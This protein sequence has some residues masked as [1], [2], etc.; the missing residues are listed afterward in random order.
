MDQAGTTTNSRRAWAQLTALAALPVLAL[1]LAITLGSRH[2]QGEQSKD[3]VLRAGEAAQLE[4][5]Q[6]SAMLNYRLNEVREE[7]LHLYGEQTNLARALT[8]SERERLIFFRRDY[9]AAFSVLVPGQGEGAAIK[10]WDVQKYFLRDPQRQNIPQ[11][12]ALFKEA[13]SEIRPPGFIVK[14]VDPRTFGATWPSNEGYLVGFISNDESGHPFALVGVFRSNNLLSFCKFFGESLGAMPTNSFVLNEQGLV[15]CHSSARFEGASFKDFSFY[16]Q[17]RAGS[18]LSDILHYTS[19]ANI[20]VSAVT[21]NVE[22]TPFVLVS[23]AGEVRVVGDQRLPR[24]IFAAFFATILVGLASAFGIIRICQR[25][26][27]AAPAPVERIPS[28]SETSAS[29]TTQNITKNVHDNI[30]GD[31]PTGPEILPGEAEAL[32]KELKELSSELL[33]IQASQAFIANFQKQVADLPPRENLG[34]FSVHSMAPWQVPMVWF[35]KFDE[36]PKVLK[37]ASAH[38]PDEITDFGMEIELPQAHPADIA[39]DLGLKQRLAE[40]LKWDVNPEEVRIQPVY[41]MRKL[42]GFFVFKN[43]STTHADLLP[44]LAQIL[45]YTLEARLAHPLASIKPEQNHE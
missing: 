42:L 23:E 2:F 35:E 11:V 39:K 45:A 38:L 41:F 26:V 8:E 37:V 10:P 21:K 22:G 33:E 31:D 3:A 18:N 13:I 15:A 7:L 36:A 4:L 17:L 25:M 9:L 12:I 43:L 5:R 29:D 44:Q 28:H 32:K 30:Q 24:S 40:R 19:A 1:L 6:L 14:Q 16:P 27:V 20:E 34:A